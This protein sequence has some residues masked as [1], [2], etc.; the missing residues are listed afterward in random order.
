MEPGGSCDEFHRL[1]PKESA[2]DC[3]RDLQKEPCCCREAQGIGSFFKNLLPRN[4]DTEDLIVI[5]LLLLLS[6]DGEK[7]RNR[8]L[9]TMGAYL[10]L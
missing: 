10:F 6:Q 1:D 7:N 8:A 3:G 2:A 5:L 9:L 4:L